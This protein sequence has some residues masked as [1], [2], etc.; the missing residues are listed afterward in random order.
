MTKHRKRPQA[1][2]IIQ[3]G[4]TYKDQARVLDLRNG[5]RTSPIPSGKSYKRRPKHGSWS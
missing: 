4:R 2:K 1:Q 3:T 5:S